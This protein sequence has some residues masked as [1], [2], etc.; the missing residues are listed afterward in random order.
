[1]LFHYR[2]F[3]LSLLPMMVLKFHYSE[4]DFLFEQNE[5]KYIVCK[6]RNG[7]LQYVLNRLLEYI[8]CILYKKDSKSCLIFKKMLKREI[9]LF[10]ACIDFLLILLIQTT[11][12]IMSF[13][14]LV[15]CI[16][17]HLL[18][19]ELKNSV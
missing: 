5:D 9:I 19:F 4:K 14:C 16:C 12:Y 10:A 1:M 11:V 15:N 6:Y 18:T 17:A 13:S 8:C 7:I 2:K 3:S